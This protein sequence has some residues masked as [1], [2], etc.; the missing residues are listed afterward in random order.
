MIR[1]IY[2]IK[3][4]KSTCVPAN[5]GREGCYVW[6]GNARKGL[7]YL[8]NDPWIQFLHLLDNILI[9]PSDTKYFFAEKNILN[10]NTP[11]L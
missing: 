3:S 7:F 9:V 2:S 10:S 11:R 1:S 4:I 6:R 5:F 8:V